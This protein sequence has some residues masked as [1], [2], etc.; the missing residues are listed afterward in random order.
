MSK[1]NLSSLEKK[2]VKILESYPDASIPIPILLDALSLTS[3]KDSKKLFNP[4]LLI[5]FQKKQRYINFVVTKNHHTP[6]FPLELNFQKKHPEKP[7]K[8]TKI[9]H[10][11]L[12]FLKKLQ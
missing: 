11:F 5:I 6:L 12:I 4:F 2:I 3:K 1:D 7:L 10:I 8:K 9:K